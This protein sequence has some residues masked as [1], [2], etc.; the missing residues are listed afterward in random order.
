C[1]LMEVIESL[2]HLF[3]GTEGT[4][5]L[6]FGP[7]CGF[8]ASFALGEMGAHFNPEIAH[9]LLKHLAT[10]NRPIV[11]IQHLGDALKREVYFG[12]RRHRGKQKPQRSFHV[13][14]VDSVIFLIRHTTAI[15]DHTID[16][17]NGTSLAVLHPLW[18]L[19]LF[20]VRRTQI[21]MPTFVA[22]LRL[23]SHRRW[24]AQKRVPVVA[25]LIQITID[26]R[27]FQLTMRSLEM[28]IRRLN[29]IFLQESNSFIR[30]QIMSLLVGGAQLN[31]G[32]DF[33]VA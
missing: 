18:R 6:P 3:Y 5:D 24:G 19:D 9:Y 20:E 33:A 7:C 29:T 10:S 1:G 12:F 26:R 13:F 31:G 25:P 17:Q 28:S 4:L 8:A 14:P 32:D 15:V 2:L 30:R 16:H 11:H 23:E 21:K 27:A 22:M